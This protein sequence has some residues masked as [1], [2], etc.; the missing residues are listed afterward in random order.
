MA[1]SSC[2]PVKNVANGIRMD[3]SV[4]KL[5]LRINLPKRVDIAGDLLGLHGINQN[6]TKTVVQYFR[7][8]PVP[9]NSS[10]RD[11]HPEQS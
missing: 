8:F 7:T 11:R 3:S 10:D 9:I 6:L 1:R 2:H 4:E 5:L